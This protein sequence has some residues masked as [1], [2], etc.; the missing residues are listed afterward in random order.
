MRQLRQTFAFLTLAATFV[1]P[2]P[3][4]AE[5]PW[6]VTKA[7]DTAV[8]RVPDARLRFGNKVVTV[9]DFG[10]RYYVW[11]DRVPV[12][13]TVKAAA[14]MVAGRGAVVLPVLPAQ[15]RPGALT[16]PQVPPV[17][18]TPAKSETPGKSEAPKPAEAPAHPNLT[19]QR[20]AAPSDDA[21]PWRLLVSPM[22]AGWVPASDVLELHNAVVTASIYTPGPAPSES[23]D[24]RLWGFA[25][26][27]LALGHLGV[28]DLA[29]SDLEQA[30]PLEDPSNT[31]RVL[32]HR[33]NLRLTARG[34]T[35]GALESAEA[36]VKAHAGDPW[37]YTVRGR[38]H[39]S[40][41]RFTRALDDYSRACELADSSGI[42]QLAGELRLAWL[43]ATCPVEPLRNPGAALAHVQ[44]ADE[45]AQGYSFEAS[46]ARAAALAAQGSFDPA[47]GVQTQA[48]EAFRPLLSR[49]HPEAIRF[50]EQR[51]KKY[52]ARRP[53]VQPDPS[54]R[55]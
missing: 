33:A 55:P 3:A 32:L 51:L 2:T 7:G 18:E 19:S 54:T 42:Y 39:E 13:L 48:L 28:L 30:V 14:A 5:D 24:Y 9:G 36:W 50:A 6:R 11:Q 4:P 29:F 35:A 8:L 1:A 52:R 40:A 44:K 16:P 21:R 34:D 20:A 41:G 46:N 49:T 53:Y 15:G 26:R 10:E 12:D 23:T 47:V 45:L 31:Y 27:G 25:T 43:L 22:A 38:L 17:A 37:G